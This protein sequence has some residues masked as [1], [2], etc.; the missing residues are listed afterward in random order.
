MGVD[1]ISGKAQSYKKAFDREAA[2]L[3]CPDLF[4]Q[5][6]APEARQV[7][8]DILPGQSVDLGET[9]TVRLIDGGMVAYRRDVVVAKF[10]SPPREVVQA[11]RDACDVA[12]AT[13]EQ[14]GLFGGTIRVSLK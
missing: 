14:V 7:Q 10:L 13:V 4:R 1:F 6:P 9:L 5:Q 12:S 11:L 8:G 3:A 2:A